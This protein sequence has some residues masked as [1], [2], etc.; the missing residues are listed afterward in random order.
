MLPSMDA[1]R[2]R[3]R[4]VEIA[5]P[6]VVTPPLLGSV[7][8]A[9]MRAF[10]DAESPLR[11]DDERARFD[12]LAEHEFP[13]IIKSCRAIA[14][15]IA[16]RSLA[17]ER[18]RLRRFTAGDFQHPDDEP[19]GDEPALELTLDFSERALG[20]GGVVYLRRGEPRFAVTQLPGAISLAATG[21]ELGRK[22]A[23]LS[24][25]ANGTA[26]YRIVLTLL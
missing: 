17:V 5:H 14:E 9:A 3:G 7:D 2:L 13:A 15:S 20:T 1:L 16:S 24:D 18:V 6:A 10:F 25:A 22:V 26:V 12:E 23:P 21:P 8:A 19:A 4:W 11:R